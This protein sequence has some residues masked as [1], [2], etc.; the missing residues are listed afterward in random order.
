MQLSSFCEKLDFM[1]RT[2]PILTN[3]AMIVMSLLEYFQN[4]Q[5]YEV[6]ISVNHFFLFVST[7]IF[8]LVT[9]KS[10]GKCYLIF[11]L[12]IMC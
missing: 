5:E 8:I 2:L 4:Y 11:L 7:V 12:I 9:L 1:A 3:K 10:G 6:G